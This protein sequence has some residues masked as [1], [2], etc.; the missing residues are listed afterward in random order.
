MTCGGQAQGPLLLVAMVTTTRPRF[1]PQLRP[2]LSLAVLLD[3][4]EGPAVPRGTMYAQGHRA[5]WQRVPRPLEARCL[6]TVPPGG[7]Q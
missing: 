6:Q 7:L 4:W 2:S 5:P 1:G 3:L